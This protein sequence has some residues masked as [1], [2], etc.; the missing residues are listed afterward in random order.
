[1]KGVLDIFMFGSAVKGKEKP[2]D[3]DICVVF[4]DKIDLEFIKRLNGQCEKKGFNAHISSL[5]G[6]NFFTRKSHALARTMLFEGKSLITNKSFA[7]V[8]GLQ[9][10]ALYTYDLSKMNK[11]KKVRFVYLLKG[12]R[13]EKGL[14]KQLHG[15]FLVPGSFI[16]PLDK[17]K[18]MTEILDSWQINHKRKRIMLIE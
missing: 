6:A 7:E 5:I 8:Y 2:G 18:E 3:V 12:R 9:P 17:D 14:I 11:S 15:M 10:L 4:F 1:M 13:K 16:I